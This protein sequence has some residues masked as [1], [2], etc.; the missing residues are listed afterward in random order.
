MPCNALARIH[1]LA[2]LAGVWLR[3]N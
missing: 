1:R 3:T 2:V